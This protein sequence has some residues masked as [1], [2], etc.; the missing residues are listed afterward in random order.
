MKILDACLGSKETVISL[1]IHNYYYTFNTTFDVNEFIERLR[2]FSYLQELKLD[3]FIFS[4]PNVIDIIAENGKNVLKFLEIFFDEVDQHSV[5]IP[6]RKWRR[7]IKSCP[8]L[9]IS[10]CISIIFAN[11]ILSNYEKKYFRKYLPS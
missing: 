5:I 2:Q 9:K 8:G 7:L 1:E 3:Y 4:E 10:F 11:T 6:A